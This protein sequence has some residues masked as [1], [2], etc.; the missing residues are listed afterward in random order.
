M[1]IIIENTAYGGCCWRKTHFTFILYMY[2]TA[3]SK[4]VRNEIEVTY[5]SPD[6]LYFI[7][8]LR[9]GRPVWYADNAFNFAFLHL[10]RENT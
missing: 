9:R 6:I 8:G 1:Q 3:R 2:C 10:K 4:L 7:T 5:Y